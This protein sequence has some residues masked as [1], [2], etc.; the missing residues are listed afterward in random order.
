MEEHL[1]KMEKQIINANNNVQKSIENLTLTLTQLLTPKNQPSMTIQNEEPPPK[2]MTEQIETEEEDNLILKLTPTQD[3]ENSQA[4]VN[5]QEKMEEQRKNQQKNESPSIWNMEDYDLDK[6]TE[7]PNDQSQ[8]SQSQMTLQNGQAKMQTQMTSQ[9]E[10]EQTISI[11]DKRIKMIESRIKLLE[12]TID[13]MKKTTP[14]HE[15]EKTKRK[16][17]N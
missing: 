9:Q 1:S 17:E 8:K 14:N 10:L 5:N 7:E 4:S 16:P 15:P 13:N 11:Q 12:E 2:S 3:Q 6:Q